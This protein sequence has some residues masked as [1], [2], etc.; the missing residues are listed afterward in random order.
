MWLDINKVLFY[1]KPLKVVT[2][3]GQC[4]WEWNAIQN[5]RIVGKGIC[6]MMEYQILIGLNLKLLTHIGYTHN[7]QFVEENE[8]KWKRTVGRKSEYSEWQSSF[9]YIIEEFCEQNVGSRLFVS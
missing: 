6:Q 9:L 1:S 2:H 3:H 5:K 4:E 7:T 8:A